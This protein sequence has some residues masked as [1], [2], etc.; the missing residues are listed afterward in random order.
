MEA[1]FLTY[2]L[3]LDREKKREGTREEK[4][5]RRREIYSL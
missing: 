5:K 2:I 1:L 4:E 3:I